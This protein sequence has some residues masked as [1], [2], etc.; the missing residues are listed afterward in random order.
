[1]FVQVF[2]G[3]VSDPAQVRS[4][5]DQWHREIGPGAIGWLGSTAGVTD[6]GTLVGVARFE[7]EDAARQNSDRPEQG[8]WWDGMAALFTSEPVFHNSTAVTVNTYGDPAQAGFV[9][10]MQGRTSDPARSRELMEN[11]TTDWSTFRPDILGN[12]FLTHD[13]DG[14]T[15]VIYFT[16]EEAARAGEKKE[17]PAEL[18]EMMEQTNALNVGD[19]TFFDL[20][21]PWLHAP[22]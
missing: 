14:W 20:K 17:P 16:S 1:M 7:S 11:D 19:P 18:Q 22:D 8:A 4:H 9:Q 5:L 13:E 12:V 6:D 3:Q 21:D 15:M 2:Q 10:V